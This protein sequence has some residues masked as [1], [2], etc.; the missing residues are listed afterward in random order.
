MR[1]AGDLALCV[2]TGVLCFGLFACTGSVLDEAGRTPNGPK[3]PGMVPT[4]PTIPEA[5]DPT[6]GKPCVT[7]EFTGTRIWRLSDEQ[8]GAAIFDLLGL[9]APEISTPGRSK[10]EFITYAE[11][12]T[13]NS[14]LAA[15]LRDSADGVARQAVADLPKLLGCA[16]GQAQPACI[17]VFIERFAARAFRRPLE[18]VEKTELKAVYTKAAADGPAEGVRLVLSA[19]LQSPSF[20]YRTELGAGATPGKPVELTPHELASSLSFFLLNSIPDAELWKVAEDGSI[21]KPEVFAKQV[22]RLLALPRVQDNLTRVHLKWVGLGDGINPDLADQNKEFTPE[23]KASLE[24]ETRL[25]FSHLL[26]K[27]GTL[28]DVLTS[29][30]GFV[31][32]RLATHYG[33]TAAVPA[34]GFAEVS[35]P[36]TERAGILTQG[37]I[38]ARYSLGHAVVFRGKYV[39]QELLCG[40]LPAPPNIPAVEEETN[41]S[42]ALPEREQVRRRLANTTC[43]AC[44]A[45]MDPLGL[46]FVQYDPVARYR[47]NDA[48]GKPIDASGTVSGSDVDGPVMNAV[49]LAA[50][51]SRS[52]TVRACIE[53]KMFS[54]ALGRMVTPADRCELQ[55]IDAYVQSKGG[56]LSELFAGIML[57]SSFRYRT[58]G[59]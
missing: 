14:A 53:E 33:V 1:S 26:T 39:R 57:S 45:L 16:A 20:L 18:P 25:F 12:F 22:T 3:P 11:L 5:V 13:V 55:R 10:A 8:Y 52:K 2:C 17:D 40:E 28:A 35:Y 19:I 44:H 9:K 27:D 34:T 58:G 23:L 59:K 7:D 36:A 46:A 37:A 42:A 56:K 32:R 51:L 31:D 21:A 54:Y 41:A 4:N 47:P 38:L 15:D 29:T 43:G 6:T 24:E 50:K 30:K 48:A 49:D